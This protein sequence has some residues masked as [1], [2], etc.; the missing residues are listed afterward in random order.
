MYLEQEKEIITR[1]LDL[2]SAPKVVD[3]MILALSEEKNRRQQFYADIDDDIKAEFINGE[4]IIH[5]PVKLE[6][7]DATGNIFKLISIFVEEHELGYVGFEKILVAF[8]RNDYEPDVV[9]FDKEKAKDFKKGMWKF[10]IPDLV[11]EVVSKST[12]SRDRGL[13]YEDY[14]AHGVKEYW[15]IDADK[16]TVEQYLLKSKKFELN[17]KANRGLLSSKVLKGFNVDIKAFFD[18]KIC[19]VELKRL[20]K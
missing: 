7:T 2:P 3:Q 9:F 13:K 4:V 16:E 20:L 8:T 6:H 1:L 17:F 19:N 18:T 12:E 14:E 10:P 15:I 5:S 11:V